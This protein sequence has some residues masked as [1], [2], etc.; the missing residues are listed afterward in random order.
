[1]AEKSIS[2]S[3]I[4]ALLP[5]GSIWVPKVD[6]DFD[7]LLD[8]IGDNSETIKNFL[9]LLARVKD[10]D[11]TAFLDDLEKEFGVTKNLNLTEQQRRDSL[12]SQKFETGGK[13]SDDNLEIH[14][15][16]AGFEVLVHNN[17][18]AVDPV[19]FLGAVVTMLANNEFGFAGHES[20]FASAGTR[21]DEDLLVNGDSFLIGDPLILMGAGSGIAFAGH[22]SALAGFFIIS[23]SVKKLYEIPADPDRFP[24]VFFVGGAATRDPG[25]GELTAIAR[26]DVP[27]ER[28]EEFKRIILKIK[29]IHSW[30]ALIVTYV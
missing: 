4:D 29:P 25:T 8:G 18:P 19:L 26:A 23:E 11:K 5:P 2:R 12:S 20:A 13:G 16:R 15:Q 22:Q 9:G 30:A 17:S 21:L 1:M 10:P 28:K 27:I 6:G 24:F 14:L 3:V 7:K